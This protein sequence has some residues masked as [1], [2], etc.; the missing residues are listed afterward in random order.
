MNGIYF[1]AACHHRQTIVNRAE[2]T[3]LAVRTLA[4]LDRTQGLALFETELTELDPHAA[5][6]LE[7]GCF[8][9]TSGIFLCRAIFEKTVPGI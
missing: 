8:M 1:L 4:D 5:I 2:P 9:Q 3:G 6:C 7:A